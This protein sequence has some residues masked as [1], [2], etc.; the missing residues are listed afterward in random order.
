MKTTDKT[1][2]KAGKLS[3][4]G[5]M[6][7]YVQEKVLPDNSRVEL[8]HDG[9]TIFHVRRFKNGQRIF[10]ESFDTLGEARKFYN[11]VKR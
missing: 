11:S 4:Y 10:W 6:C 9:G 7:G 5:F 3:H 8:Y 1:R 2:T